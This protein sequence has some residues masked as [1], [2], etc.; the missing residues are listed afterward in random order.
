MPLEAFNFKS[1]QWKHK[2]TEKGQ[3]ENGH[4]LGMCVYVVTRYE[5]LLLS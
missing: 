3:I 4:I 2:E 5:K 1:P